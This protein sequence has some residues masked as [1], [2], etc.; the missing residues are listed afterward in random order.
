MRTSMWVPYAFLAPA[1]AGLLVFRVAPV[2][3]ALI[4]GFF[5]TSLTGETVFAGLGNYQGLADDPE[6]W[7]SVRITLLFNLVIN[8]LQVALAFLLALLMAKPGRGVGALRTA[9]LLPITVSIALTSVLWN[10][11]LDPGVGPVNGVLR[12]LGLP[13]QP[14]FRSAGEA[15]PSIIAMCTWRGVGYWMLFMLAGLGSIPPEVNEAAMIDGAGPWRRMWHVTLPLM[16]RT[17]AFVLIADTAAN[18]LLFAPVYII[19]NG[20]PA[21]STALLMFEAYRAAFTLLDDGRSL[22][23]SSVILLIVAAVA[24]L[25]MRVFRA[26]EGV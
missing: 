9:V 3:L 14:F 21:G 20:G 4:G 22:A 13:A 18:F 26:E 5:G 8:P 23:L 19:T 12:S 16:R 6:F 25:E 11:L 7:S 17:F 2:I 15:L 24:S 10:L 1:L